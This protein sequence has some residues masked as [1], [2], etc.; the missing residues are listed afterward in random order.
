MS[1]LLTI[2]APRFH[3]FVTPD[4]SGGG[5]A[6][7]PSGLA[8]VTVRDGSITAARLF[9]TG[10]MREDTERGRVIRWPEEEKA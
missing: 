4:G 3:L 1:A 8:S 7:L 10:R 2:E 5:V 9:P 6:F